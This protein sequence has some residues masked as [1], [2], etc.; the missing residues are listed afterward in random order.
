[1]GSSP[2][3]RASLLL[4][5]ANPEDQKAW[6]EFVTLYEPLVHRLL[7]KSGLQDAD[8]REV[9]QEVFLAV[10]RNVARFEPAYEKGSFR[11][12]LRTVTRNLLVN[13]LE[14][15]R[16]KLGA[17]TGSTDMLHLIQQLPAPDCETSV[18][19][20]TEFRR[21]LFHH[22][23]DRVRKEFRPATWQAFWQTCVEQIPI[24]EV[25][26][27]LGITPGAVYI[28]RSR[29]I[30]RLRAEVDRIDREENQ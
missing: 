9:T 2:T 28:A 14:Q 1:M 10:S 27:R 12:W 20:D 11:G 26:Q 19:V 30:T 17:G 25:C 7:R 18:F 22:A 13:L 6:A 29:V 23:A 8:L 4:R 5:L 15:R 16:R 3:T 24:A 21:R